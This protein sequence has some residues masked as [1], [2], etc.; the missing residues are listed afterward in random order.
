MDQRKTLHRNGSA[1]DRLQPHIF[2]A[3][4]LWVCRRGLQ[5][6]YTGERLADKLQLL[7]ITF[8]KNHYFYIT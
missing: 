6:K 3:T 4:P 5:E 7:L 2:P 1:G 8:K